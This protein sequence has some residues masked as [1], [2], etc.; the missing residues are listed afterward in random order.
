MYSIVVDVVFSCSS[1]TVLYHFGCWQPVVK[2]IGQV[3]FVILGWLFLFVSC[4]YI[5]EW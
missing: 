5:D 1:W 3:L 4:V 2:Q